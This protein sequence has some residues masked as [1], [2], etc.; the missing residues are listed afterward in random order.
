MSSHSSKSRCGRVEAPRAPPSTRPAR[1]TRAQVLLVSLLNGFR[2]LTL[3]GVQAFDF[4]HLSNVLISRDYRKAR[5]IDIDGNSKGS[6]QAVSAGGKYIGLDDGD[7][8]D[9]ESS[10]QHLHKPALEVPPRRAVPRRRPSV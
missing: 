4:N 10:A 9:D 5:L 7:G 3:M 2:D 1:S 8:G 6:I